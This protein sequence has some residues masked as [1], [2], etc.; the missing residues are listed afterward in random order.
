MV[1]ASAPTIVIERVQA[2][3]N[4]HDLD[5]LMD[6]FHQDVRSEQP[7]RPD[8]GFRGREEL[9]GYWEKLAEGG[10]VTMPLEVAPWG[11][12]FGQLTDKFGVAWM[13]NIAG[14]GRA[15]TETVGTAASA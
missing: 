15:D 2:A 8:R 9:R 13:V 6:C 7:T 3:I 12:A 5:A 4:R 11:D 1:V 10:S 14:S